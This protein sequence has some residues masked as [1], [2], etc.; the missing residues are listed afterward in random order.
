MSAPTEHPG[1]RGR[2]AWIRSPVVLFVVVSAVLVG[3]IFVAT[4]VIADD[5]ATEAARA[6]AESVSELLA[7]TTAEPYVG[8]GLL[9]GKPGASDRFFRKAPNLLQ[10][11]DVDSVDLFASDGTLIYSQDDPAAV[12]IMTRE[13]YELS[14]AQRDVL[15][16]G[17]TGSELADPTTQRSL[18]RTGNE[19]GLVK[20]FT[21]IQTP[22]GEPVLFVAYWALDGLEDRRTQIFGSFRWITL[23]PLMLLS[24]ISAGMLGLLTMQVRR[25]G[26]ERERL[27]QSAMDA[28][29]AERRRIARDLHDG[30]VQDLAGTAF[31]LSAVARDSQ[32]P[33]PVRLRLDAAGASLRDGLKSLRS[34][35]AEIH[36]PDLHGKGLSSALSDLLAPASAAGIGASVSVDGLEEAPEAEVALLWRV[37]QEAVRNTLRHAQAST[38]AVTVRGNASGSLLEVVDDGTGFD[39]DC[40]SGPEH[41]GLTGLRSLVA[42]AGGHLEVHSAPGEGTTV[43]LAVRR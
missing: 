4:N 33:P 42:D 15:A 27:L 29:D 34:L 7:H 28:S 21:Q 20:I 16:E 1:P 6:Q 23:G 18:D 11:K 19:D 24:L 35:L 32:V 2:T 37:A 36:P 5:A 31:S 9:S 22:R 43:R 26:R 25:A 38:L 17:G 3:A 39:Q 12:P 13:R 14:D 10:S 41:F 8:G 40:A 30:V